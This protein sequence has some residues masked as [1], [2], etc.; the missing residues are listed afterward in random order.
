M[1]YELKRRGRWD[2][3]WVAVVELDAEECEAIAAGL[4][5]GDGGADELFD[6]ADRIRELESGDD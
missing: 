3:R 4:P 6:A 5:A 1:A 2:R